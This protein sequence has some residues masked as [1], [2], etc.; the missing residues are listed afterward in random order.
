MKLTKET[1]YAIR[2][3]NPRDYVPYFK[4]GADHETPVLFK[5]RKQ[6]EAQF[7]KNAGWKVVRVE[8]RELK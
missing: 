8:L 7:V 1:Y 3:G 6:A 4:V 5:I 2:I